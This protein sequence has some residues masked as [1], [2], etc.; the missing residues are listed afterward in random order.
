VSFYYFDLIQLA[1]LSVSIMGAWLFFKKKKKIFLAPSC[2][3]VISFFFSPVNM[4]EKNASSRFVTQPLEVER[5]S[6]KKNNFQ[7]SQ[8]E[9]LNRLEQLSKEKRNEEIN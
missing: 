7:K 1:A 4:T 9:K 6:F 2:L 3:L 8:S 5:V